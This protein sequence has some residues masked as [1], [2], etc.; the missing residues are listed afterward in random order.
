M[1]NEGHLRIFLEPDLILMIANKHNSR[2]ESRNQRGNKPAPKIF[3]KNIQTSIISQNQRQL[4][5]H[6]LIYLQ[7]S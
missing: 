4:N 2:I 3:F 6:N 1:V 5:L 7:Y